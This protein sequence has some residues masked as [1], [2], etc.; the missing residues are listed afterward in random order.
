VY[1]NATDAPDHPSGVAEIH[2]SYNGGTTWYTAAGNTTFTIPNECEHTIQW[3]AVDNLG[4]TEGTQSRDVK[5]DDTPPLVNVTIGEPKTQGESP[6]EYY[7]TEDTP[8]WINVTDVGQDPCI[9]GS[10]NLTVVVEYQG[11]EIYNQSCEVQDGW[12]QLSLM[13][14]LFADNCTHY[15]NITARDDIGNVNT[16]D[17]VL[18]VFKVDNI[19]PEST[20]DPIS[21]YCQNVTADNPL[22]L[23]GTADDAGGCASGV[24]NVTLWYRYARYNHSFTNWSR[25]DTYTTDTWNYDFEAPNGSGYYQFYTAAYDN[26]SN[27]EPMPNASSMPKAMVSVSYNHSFELYYNSTGAN[28]FTMPVRHPDIDRASDLIT[29]INGF[30]A[31]D[32]CTYVS[33]W[34]ADAQRYVTYIASGAGRDFAIMPGRGYLIW[35]QANISLY[36][37]GCLIEYDAVNMSLD[38]GYSMIGWNNIEDTQ[39]NKV[40][41]NI[42]GCIKLSKYDAA[43]QQWLIEYIVG[44]PS[45]NNF[46]ITMDDAIF[47]YRGDNT[48]PATW[49]G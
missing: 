20:I 15:V 16:T 11:A 13:P 26:L 36:M 41:E 31:D 44:L 24:Q 27:H 39:A 19:E 37:E 34:D 6:Y 23:H 1:L 30:S 9:V 4:N 47:V 21:P 33:Y 17:Y 43:T 35:M 10:V 12:A 28:Y 5:V 49:T 25:L 7:A 32:A 45:S 38:E 29:Y 40:A 3:Y 46:G 48:P 8:V 18:H 22:E 14:P 42:S 2:Y